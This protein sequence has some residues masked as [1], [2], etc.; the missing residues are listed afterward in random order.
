MQ[1]KIGKVKQITRDHGRFRV[2]Q[3]QYLTEKFPVLSYGPTPDIELNSWRLRLFG[4]VENEVTVTWEKFLSL[5]QIT[6]TRDFHCVT[7]WSR[8]DNQWEG[9]S[10]KDILGLARTKPEVCFVMVHCYGGYT[11]NIS[12][13]V[14]F[15]TD[16]LFA[17]RHDG[18]SLHSDHGGPVRLVVPSRYGW[19]S[20][21]W[22]SGLELMAEDRMGFWEQLGF[23]NN[24]DPWR[25]ERF[26]SSLT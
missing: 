24:G 23:H 16:V 26:W 12:L 14:L 9:V 15:E 13:D 10:A 5:P 3:G 18:E 1:R 7:Q 4:L 2:P 17:H 20:A 19:K 21:K 6:V 25:E 22:V 11:T 8:M